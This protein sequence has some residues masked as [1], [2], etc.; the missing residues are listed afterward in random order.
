MHT[1]FRK[2]YLDIYFKISSPYDIEINQMN[3]QTGA[4]ARFF[5]TAHKL[6]TTVKNKEQLWS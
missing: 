1:K 2:F 5:N 6:T 4:T 3:G